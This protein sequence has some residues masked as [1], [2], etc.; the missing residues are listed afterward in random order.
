MQ[1][2]SFRLSAGRALLSVV[3]LFAISSIVTGIPLESTATA[4]ATSASGQYGIFFESAAELP[5]LRLPYATYQA[6]SYDSKN[7]V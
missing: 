4:N 5:T 6:K 2:L 3:Q 1:P 7:D